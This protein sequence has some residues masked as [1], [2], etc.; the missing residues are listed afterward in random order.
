LLYTGL[1]AHVDVLGHQHHLAARKL[2]AQALHHAQDL[3]VGLALR[4]PGGQLHVQQRGLEEQLAA[5]F[6]VPGAGQFDAGLGVEL[7]AFAA[8]RG[9][10][11]QRIQLAADLAHAARHLAH[12]LLVAVELLERDHRQ[13]HVVFLEAEQAHRVVHQHVGVQ[14]EELGRAAVLGLAGRLGLH[15]RGGVARRLARG[16]GLRR[17]HRGAGDHGGAAVVQVK[18]GLR[19]GLGRTR[20]QRAFVGAR[21]GLR[22]VVGG[23][24]QVTLLGRRLGQRHRGQAE[25]GG[26]TEVKKPLGRPK[27]LFGEGV[28]RAMPRQR[29]ARVL[30]RPSSAPSLP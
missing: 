29:C 9:D 19:R 28:A 20:L 17:L 26:K 22:F 16:H 15:R 12:A 7:A 24:Q 27:R 25:V 5:G 8:L 30:K 18:R 6:A 23:L 3:V 14:H 10:G 21:R 2:L 4:Q 1:H 13:E 11:S